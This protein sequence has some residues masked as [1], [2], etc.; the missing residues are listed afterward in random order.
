MGIE[1]LCF[2]MA[3]GR[4][5]FSS[6]A[7]E[8][9]RLLG[10]SPRLNRQAIHDYL[11]SHM[12]P[13]PGT[14]FDGVRKLQPATFAVV[15]AL[16]ARVERYWSPQFCRDPSADVEHLTTEL[17]GALDRAVL[18]CGIDGDTGAFLS[19]GLDSSTVAGVLHRV[20][21]QP[22]KT[23]SMGFGVESY[24]E[25]V[26]AQ[27]A[28][29]HFGCIGHELHVT[30]RDIVD[31]FDRI[32]ATYDEPFGNS[33]ALPTYICA[34]FAA[35]HG[36]THLLAGDGGDEIFGGNERY[37]RQRVFELYGK[38]PEFLRRGLL[39][40]VAAAIDPESPIAPL[41]K[42]RSYVDQA[43]IALPDRLESYN[44]VHREGSTRVFDPDFLACVDPDAPMRERRSVYG[45][46]DD[47]E[48]VDRL[49]H[50]DWQYTLADNDLRK[51]G[52]M[53]ELAGVRVSYP[54]LDPE[55][56]ALSLRVPA[57]MKVKGPT[58]R[59][60]YKRAMANFLPPEILNKPKHGFGLPFGVWLKTEEPLRELIYSH[61]DSLRSRRIVNAG[62]I[63]DLRQQ[64][65]DGDAS[66][67]GY[68][69]W[70]LAQLD[71][72]LTAHDL[73]V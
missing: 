17:H 54:M 22:V 1:R 69:I 71:A 40:R 13:A 39:E 56:I 6:S 66:F 58:L 72:W 21:Q 23:F 50:Y 70:D 43:R 5:A 14:V 61:L 25:L 26:Y 18:R 65:R 44:F 60:F 53:C 42:F 7:L 64:H 9:P 29:R 51:V 28:N 31:N 37:A 59:W 55:V 2:G 48:M 62:F 11:I 16:G 20:T 27:T 47:A 10:S 30:A 45:S 4:F 34:R 36:V 68:P 46:V 3:P 38:V 32:A 52:T 73:D 67:H 41:R 63:D 12:V 35:A 15:D 24:D 33:S 57:G 19:G 8:V 49:L